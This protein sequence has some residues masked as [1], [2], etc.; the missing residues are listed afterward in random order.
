M[1]TA[2]TLKTKSGNCLFGRNMDL[3]Y[4]FNQS[5]HLVPRKFN[6]KNV[7]TNEMEE[8]KYA[9]IGMATIIEEHPMFADGLNEKGLGCAGLNFPGYAYYEKEAVEGKT[10]IPTHDVILWILANFETIQEVKEAFKNVEIIGKPMTETTELPTLHWIVT[11]KS[12]DSIVI[13]RTKEALKVY[14]NK[15][16]V[17]TNSPTFDWHVTN[18]RQ[19]MAVSNEQPKTTTWFEQELKPLGEGLGCWGLPG[20]FSTTSRFVRIAFLKSRADVVGDKLE[21]VSEFFHMLNNVAMPRYSVIT[22]QGIQDITQYT[23]CMCQSSGVYYYNTY[24]NCRINAVDMH[25][26]NLDA[27]EIKDFSYMDKMDINENN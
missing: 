2:L 11:D 10:N 25:K 19:Y 20:D 17:L 6:Y 12:G 14:D 7:A 16:G 13:E 9:I 26:E 22:P 24:N 1:C 4:G 3:G 27:T 5:V 8:V 15:V 21:G 23:C 18:L